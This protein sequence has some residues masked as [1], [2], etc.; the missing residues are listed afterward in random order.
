MNDVELKV[1]L[2]ELHTITDER[3]IRI[4][5]A[6]FVDVRLAREDLCQKKGG[7]EFKPASMHGPCSEVCAIC[8]KTK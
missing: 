6:G 1:L 2:D 8:G 4:T 3:I 7:H 5:N